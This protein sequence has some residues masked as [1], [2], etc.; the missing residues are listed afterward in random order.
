MRYE[1]D[2]KVENCFNGRTMKN[3]R[4]SGVVGNEKANVGFYEGKA[5]ERKSERGILTNP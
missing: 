3:W 2:I 4:K 5:N 1:E